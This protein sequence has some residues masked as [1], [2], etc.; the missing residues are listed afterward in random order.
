MIPEMS[1][2]NNVFLG[3]ERAGKLKIL[4]D[5]RYMKKRA[6]PTVGEIWFKAERSGSIQ[7]VYGRSAANDGN[8]PRG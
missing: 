5:T 3:R 4:F 2:Y 1:V 6:A 8:C 7:K